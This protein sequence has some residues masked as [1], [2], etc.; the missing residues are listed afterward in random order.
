MAAEE[1]T[2]GVVDRMDM[3]WEASALAVVA[4]VAWMMS[5]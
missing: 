5:A 4:V 1:E 3:A 2:Y